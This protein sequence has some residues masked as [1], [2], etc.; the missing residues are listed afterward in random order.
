MFF[1][2]RINNLPYSLCRYNESDPL[3]KISKSYL[4]THYQNL[5]IMKSYDIIILLV[6]LTFSFQNLFSKSIPSKI[7]EGNDFITCDYPIPSIDYNSGGTVRFKWNP[8]STATSYRL[9]YRLKGSTNSWTTIEGVAITHDVTNLTIGSEYEYKVNIECNGLWNDLNQAPINYFTAN[10]SPSNLDLKIIATYTSNGVILRWAPV[11]FKSWSFGNLNGYELTRFT[12]EENGQE[13]TIAE[14][15]AS[16]VILSPQL[17]PIPEDDWDAIYLQ[18]EIAAVAA[19]AIYESEFV[20]EGNSTDLVTTYNIQKQK[21]NRFGLSLFAADQSFLVAE[22]MG[23]GYKD[24]TINPEN[25]YIYRVKYNGVP[26]VTQSSAG[27]VTIATTAGATLP[28]PPGLTAN[29]GN[30]MVNLSWIDLFAGKVYSSYD[31]ERS[32]D[33]GNTFLKVNDGPVIHPSSGNNSTSSAA[34][35]YIDSLQQNDT[36]Y[37]YRVLGKSPFGIYGPPSDTVIVVGKPSPLEA[38]T[39]ITTVSKVDSDKLAN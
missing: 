15:E 11:D 22:A 35:F 27:V 13:L 20:V 32:E 19:A 16:K 2:T 7:E 21:E 8:D 3:N 25:K 23:L 10:E 36:E 12:K 4:I 5:F 6:I 17:L 24:N 14:Q 30:L 1:V 29:A 18:D 39:H 34:I 37:Q 38:F 33:G 28:Q 31:I 9:L 26:T